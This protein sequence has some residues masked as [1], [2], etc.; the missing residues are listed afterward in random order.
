[1][2]LEE[3]QNKL[4][5]DFDFS[6]AVNILN[7]IGENFT[8]NDL[9]ENAKGLIK[10][11]YTSREMDYVFFESAYL[12]ATRN[13]LDGV[14]VYYSLNFSMDI[15]SNLTLELDEPFNDKVVTEKEFILK[16]EL[17]NLLEENVIYLEENSVNEFIN[18]NIIKIKEMLKV[19]D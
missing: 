7:K 17:Q 13:Y 6:K 9:I 11:T 8:E 18:Q 19:L 4:I 16:E 10:M 5:N 12:S 2:N 15:Q 1:M 14:E 3:I